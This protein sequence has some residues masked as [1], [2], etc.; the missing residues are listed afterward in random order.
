[1][2][3][4]KPVVVQYHGHLTLTLDFQDQILK[5]LYLRY[6]RADW[7]GTKW[8]WVYGTLDPHCDFKLWQ[9]CVLASIIISWKSTIP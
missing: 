4:S 8:M 3:L 5:M 9:V 7:H 6:D 2:E 1:M